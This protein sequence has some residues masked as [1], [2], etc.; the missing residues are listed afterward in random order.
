MVTEV[1]TLKMA[2]TAKTYLVSGYPR[3]MRDVAE[4]SDKIQ[5]ISG[6]VLVSWR[7]RVLERQIEYGARLGHVVLSLA[8][9][10]LNNF[11]RSVMPVAEYF[12]QSGMLIAVSGI[13]HFTH[14]SIRVLERQI[15]YGA[16][17][18]HVALSLARM[19]LNNFYRSVMP[20]AEYFDQSGM[21][22]ARVL[23]R[24]IEYGARLGHVVLSL[25][26]MELNNFYRSVMPVAEYFDQ[27]GMLIARVLERQ[28]EYGARLGH[29]ALSLARMELNNFYRSVMPVAEYFDQSGMLIA[30]DVAYI[31]QRVLERQIEYGARLGHVALSLA[32]MELNNFYRSVM[33]VAEYFDQSGMLIALDVAYIRQRVLERQI[34]YGARLGHV[35]LSLARMEL[36]NFYRSVMPVAEYFDQSGMLIALDVA[37]IRQRVLERQIEYG[38][39]LGH[40]ALSLARMELNNFYRSV[41]PVAEYFDQSGM[42]IA[43]VLE[44]QI[45]YGARLGHVALSLARMELNNF[46]RSVMPVAEYFDQ[47]GMLIAV[48]GERNPEEVYKDFRAAVL[49]ILGSVEDQSTMNGVS[50]VGVGAGG[51]P[52]EIVGVEPAPQTG[53]RERVRAEV[54][55]VMPVNGDARITSPKM[56]TQRAPSPAQREEPRPEVLPVGPMAHMGNGDIPRMVSP[57][58]EVIRVKGASTTPAILWVVGGPGSNKAALCQRCVSLRPG[59]THFSLGQRLRSLADAGGGPA[60]DGALARTAISGGE[61]A[62]R[63]LVTQLVRTAVVDAGRGTGLLLDGY[64]R[65]LE[66]MEQF[67]KEFRVSPRMVLLDCSK[68]QLGRGRRDDSVAAFRRRLEVFRELSLPML[69]TLDQHHRLVIVDGDTD[70]SDVQQEF[71]KVVQEEMEKAEAI[72]IMPPEPTEMPPTPKSDMS[73]MQQFTH[74]MSRMGGGLAN[75]FA[76][77]GLRN[78]N[79]GNGTIPNGNVGNGFIGM[80]NN[81]VKPIMNNVAKIPTVSQMTHDEV[82]RLYEQSS[83][84]V[85][86]LNTHM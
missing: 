86:T 21:L 3:S 28:I 30:L 46:Y 55:P 25:A 79:V 12:D 70:S 84:E 34:E 22:I 49:Q 42:L 71:M 40:V 39:R 41:M 36:N 24:Q 62:P 72:A 2:P 61:L 33:P 45:E 38:A 8:R 78:G 67:Q 5:T 74:A 15:E 56:G 10:E 19:E 4:Y 27:S 31:R 52:G 35:A 44:R 13:K 58:A 9:M 18:G 81:K 65:D 73:S 47:S 6:V 69:K 82:R 75:G 64:P 1:L 20:V 23:E 77:G 66:Q 16:R 53:M 26:R 48:N 14:S 50:G 57:K 59:W 43:R 76:N 7:Q 51:I 17:L 60:S 80:A 85:M 32:R 83:G 11:Y 54:L 29:V 37:Y 68:L 63:D